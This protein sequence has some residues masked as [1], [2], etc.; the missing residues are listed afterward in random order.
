LDIALETK[1]IEETLVAS[2]VPVQA[3]PFRSGLLKDLQS[4]IIAAPVIR[5]TDWGRVRLRFPFDLVG[6]S[7]RDRPPHH[8]FTFV[9]DGKILFLRKVDDHDV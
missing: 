8:V 4:F 5:S 2:H 3:D 6:G 9:K 7:Q 1:S